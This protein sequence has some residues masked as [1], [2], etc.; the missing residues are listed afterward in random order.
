MRILLALASVASITYATHWLHMSEF[1]RPGDEGVLALGFVL[2]G[3][4]L[5]GEIAS[6]VRLPLIS[7][8]LLTGVFFGPLS[9]G[10]LPDQ[11]VPLSS[12]AV[13]R[14]RVIDDLA[15]GLIAFTAGGEIKIGT[16][17]ERG[18]L[19]IAAAGLQG[20]WTFF[21]VAA[22]AF[23]VAPFFPIGGRQPVGMLTG[24]ALLLGASMVPNSPAT[25]VAVVN[26]CRARG[27]LTDTVMSVTVVKDIV[28]VLIFMVA[29]SAAELLILGEGR[30][31]GTM[32]AGVAW[33]ISGSIVVG[34]VLGWLMGV[35]IEKV[36]LE[37]P[38]VVVGLGFLSM[39]LSGGVELSGLLICMVAGF[40]V[41]NFSRHGQALI[42][43]V[44]TYSLP[45]YVVFFTVAGASV[46]LTSLREM[47]PLATVMAA[48]RG[49]AIYAGTRMACATEGDPPVLRRYSWLGFIGQAGVSL[50]LARIIAEA[51]PGVGQSLSTVIIATITINQ[52]IGPIALRWAI[53]RA[54]EANRR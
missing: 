39:Y 33:E 52:I 8:Y 53:F 27:K 37:L 46:D 26:E 47:W 54:G 10:L 49:A 4:F 15:L 28:A 36:G 14:L 44:E 13:G 2:L 6:R 43:A 34:V 45:V 29:L 41:E 48:A 7:G 32:I 31:R 25:V 40:T 23:L 3:S 38:A 11:M 24:C 21:A 16:L 42:Q 22:A 9:A 5:C 18:R 17:R 12:S 20:F 50:G 19:I 30:T 35:Y 1:A 51:L